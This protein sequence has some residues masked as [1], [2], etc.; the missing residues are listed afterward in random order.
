M[1][2]GFKKAL[3]LWLFCLF[4]ISGS[5]QFHQLLAQTTKVERI[6]SRNGLSD[7]NIHDIHE[8]RYG[9][10]WIST[11]HGLNKYD[12]LKFEVFRHDPQDTTSIRANSLGRIYEDPQANIWVTVDVG[13]VCKYDRASGKFSYYNYD[14]EHP[15]NRNNFPVTMAFDRN[16]RIWAGTN[17]GINLVI[18]D[19]YAFKPVAVEGYEKI[20][21]TNVRE[22]SDGSIWLAA[23]EGLFLFNETSGSFEQVFCQG[24]T[25][26]SPSHVFEDSDKHL[27]VPTFNNELF[28]MSSSDRK[29]KKIPLPNS[30]HGVMVNIFQIADSPLMISIRQQGIFKWVND[31]WIRVPMESVEPELFRFAFGRS[32]NQQTLVLTM[33]N[34]VFLVDRGGVAKLL[35]DSKVEYNSFWFDENDKTVWFGTRGLGVF[36]VV[37]QDYK[38]DNITLTSNNTEDDR[39]ANLVTELTESTNGDIYFVSDKGLMLWHPATGKIEPLLLYGKQGLNVSIN[40]VVELEDD[41]LL[42]TSEGFFLF[43]KSSRKIRRARGLPTAGRVNGITFDRTGQLIA[44]GHFGVM[45][46]HPVSGTVDYLNDAEGYP[47]LLQSVEPR[48]VFVDHNNSIW[49]ATVRE[50]MFR[51]TRSDSGYAYQQFKYSGVKKTGFKSQTVNCIFEDSSGRLWVGGFSSGLMEF[52]RDTEQWINHTPQGNLPIP[53][54]QSIEEAA[55][56]CLWIAAI[57]G[58]HKYNPELKKFKRY[59]Y[60]EGLAS[61]TFLLSSSLHARNGKLYFGSTGGI[62][63]F[64]PALLSEDKIDPEIQ[65]EQIRLFDEPLMA[66]EPVQ[67]LKTLT[68]RH[69]QNFIGFDFIS[70]NYTNPEDIVY[71]YKLEGVDEDWVYSGVTRKVNYASI[72]PGS[73]TFRVKAGRS[74]G[75]WSKKEASIVIHILSPFWKRWWFYALVTSFLV[76]VLYLIYYLRVRQKIQRLSFMESIRKKAA[77]DFHDEMGNKLT[78]IALFSEVLGRKLNG[79]SPETKE[80]V[81]KIKDNSRNLNNSMRDFLWALDPKKDSAYDLATMLKDFGEELFDK[82]KTTFSADQIPDQLKEEVLTM[83]WKRHLVMTF[84]EAMHNV[85]KHANAKNVTLQLDLTDQKLIIALTDDGEGFEVTA[86]SEGYGLRNMRSRIEELKGELKIQSKPGLGTTIRFEGSVVYLIKNI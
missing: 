57:D 38:F 11:S 62:T 76:S 68:F 46:R 83:D 15:S 35:S 67:E 74:S 39:F 82:T 32:L 86:A 42:G 30:S 20:H 13:G 79:S 56:G 2:F 29:I 75:D 69:G 24:E 58:L 43:D 36:K 25:I 63:V 50:G 4:T 34:Q 80:Y 81:E 8:D 54:I 55:D 28:Q 64:D 77:A 27:W 9:Y 44:I 84:K 51:I 26:S 66:E 72:P 71:T 14:S 45:I 49:L 59:T 7:D 60:Q 16:G 40:K 73:Y 70:I 31:S 17:S 48:E 85:L 23:E 78:R 37:H 18:T 65:I 3:K 10:K 61:N 52:D 22:T 19:A 21:V 53:N 6:D 5:S 33:D 1:P 12:G 41:L 47:E